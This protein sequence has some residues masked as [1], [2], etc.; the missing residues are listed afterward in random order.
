MEKSI[1]AT[2]LGAPSLFVKISLLSRCSCIVMVSLGACTTT[3]VQ[4]DAVQM[5]EQVVDYYNDEIMD[6]LIRARNGQPFVHVDVAGLQAVVGSKLAGSASAGETQT[7]TT[8]T[9]PATTVAGVVGTLSRMVMRPFAVSVNPERSENLTVTST[10]VIGLTPDKAGCPLVPNIYDLYLR[11]LNLK[12]PPETFPGN[13][14]KS[15]F[16]YLKDGCSSV[17]IACTLEQRQ[18]LPRYVPGTLKSRDSCLYYVPIDYQQAYLELFRAL[19]TT[20]R[21]ASMAPGPPSLL[22]GGS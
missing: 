14:K 12:A 11:F 6:N 20:K 16:S 15:D 7:H 1:S 22:I 10:P 8:G 13:C 3:H 9:S 18:S 17:G 21:P 4:W 5:R 2:S 19:L